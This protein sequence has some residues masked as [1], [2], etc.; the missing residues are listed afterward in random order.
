MDS[1]D[2]TT[3]PSPDP[4]EHAEPSVDSFGPPHAQAISDSLHLWILIPGLIALILI[5]EPKR[6]RVYF[7]IILLSLL[8]L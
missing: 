7:T 4:S 6:C 8:G 3:A 2:P 1:A 5:G